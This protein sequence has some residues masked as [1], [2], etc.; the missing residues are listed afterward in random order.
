MVEVL[1]NKVRKTQQ[2]KNET[3]GCDRTN[4][5]VLCIKEREIFK[6]ILDELAKAEKKDKE[7]LD[8]IDDMVQ[9]SREYSA[10]EI[11]PRRYIALQSELK[12]NSVGEEQSC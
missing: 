9:R 7:L 5:I 12:K 8:I 1:I 11:G 3:F 6:K 10:E 2:C 4:L